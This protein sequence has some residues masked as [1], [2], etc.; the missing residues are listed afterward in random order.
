M[1]ESKKTRT[2]P[3]EFSVVFGENTAV[4][5]GPQAEETADQFAKYGPGVGA[6]MG[7]STV[8]EPAA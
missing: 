6:L 4:F 5:S 8:S 7:V 1:A 3:P 2:Y